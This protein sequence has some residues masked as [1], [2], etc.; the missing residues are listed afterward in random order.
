MP[1]FFSRSSLRRDIT[2]ILVFKLCVILL[3]SVTLFGA[4]NRL[5]VDNKVM[6]NHFFDPKVPEN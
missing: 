2:W 4:A 6:T 5:L 1:S 3:A